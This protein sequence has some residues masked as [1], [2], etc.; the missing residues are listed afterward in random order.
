MTLAVFFSLYCLEAGLFFLLAP[1]TRFWGNSPL[2]HYSEMLGALLTNFYIRGLVSGVGLAHIVIG[3][4]EIVALSRRK[5][6]F[7]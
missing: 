6:P 3:A 1:W 7:R 4:R 5:K 2:F